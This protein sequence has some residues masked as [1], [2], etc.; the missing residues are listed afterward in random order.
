MYENLKPALF[1]E[2][3]SKGPARVISV[4]SLLALIGELAL[5]LDDLDFKRESTTNGTRT[6]NR[7]RAIF[8]LRTI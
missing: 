8:C 1:A 4:S 5:D 6:A 7:K 2:D 3:S